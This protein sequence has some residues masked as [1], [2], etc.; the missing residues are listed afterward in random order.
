M[1]SQTKPEDVSYN[2]NQ[3]LENLNLSLEEQIEIFADILVCMIIKELEHES[4]K[5]S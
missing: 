3:Q 5:Q 4:K 2:N 1:Y